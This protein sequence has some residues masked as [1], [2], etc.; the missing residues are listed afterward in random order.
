[1]A[2]ETYEQIVKEI[3]SAP[4][5]KEVPSVVNMNR[6]L[7]W[8]GHPEKDFWII[9]VAGTNGK[10]STCAFL[11][12]ILRMM[13]YKT[14]LFTSPHLVSI[15]ERIQIDRENTDRDAL[16][17]AYQKIGKVRKES[18]YGP[19]TF[20]EQ[21]LVIALLIFQEKKVD[22]AV[23]EAGMGGRSDATNALT[24]VLSIVTAVG[25]D[26]MEYLGETLEEIAGEKAGIMKEGVPCILVDHQ[27]EVTSVFLSEAEKK[28]VNLCL[29]PKDCFK[30][31]KNN[32]KVIDFSVENRYYRNSTLTVQ[33][34]GLY[35]AENGAVAATAAKI[36]FPE[37]SD[38]I[39][40][41]ALFQAFWPGRMEEVAEGVVLDGAHNEPSIQAFME[42]VRGDS[43]TGKNRI[44]VFA[45]AADKDYQAMAE[46]LL[47][48]QDFRTVILTT[49]PYERIEDPAKLRPVFEIYETASV[50]TEASMEKACEMAFSMKEKEDIVYFAGSL[51]FIGSL[52]QYL[53]GDENDDR[54]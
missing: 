39:I 42:S 31:L 10:G 36:L 30:I 50:Y 6:Y 16:I 23:I 38:S 21:I 22:Y 18:G 2:E 48:Q 11:E 17:R 1:M 53:K 34:R 29:L 32:G 45:V 28:A 44:L 33:S 12:S 8:L 14:G 43:K 3:L 26:H 7:K 37:I 51:Y 20:F 15:R 40:R 52:E 54:F 13:G 4:R 35:Q 27:K 25:M 19:L 9:H 5:F 47:S 41:K 24:P 49:I 46:E